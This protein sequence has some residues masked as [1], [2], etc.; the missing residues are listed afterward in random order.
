VLAGWENIERRH[1]FW[2][3]VRALATSVIVIGLY[4]VVPLVHHVHD[5]ILIRLSVG[6]SLF[7]AALAYEVAAILRAERPILRAADALALVIPI[8]VVVFSW[9]YITMARSAPGSF[10]QPLDRVSALYFTVTVFTTVGFGDIAPK[11]DAARLVVMAQMVLDVV[12]IAVVIRLIIEAGRGTF[13]SRAAAL[14]PE[15]N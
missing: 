9:S 1:V 6:M 15:E 3:A 12:V 5:S 2:T 7:A 14:S 4:F 10:T 8:F 13:G 11:T